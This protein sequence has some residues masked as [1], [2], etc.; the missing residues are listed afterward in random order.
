M[1]LPAIHLQNLTLGYGR[2]KLIQHV[3]IEVPN[4]ALLAVVGANGAGKSTLLKALMGELKPLQG[5]INFNG[6]SQRDIAYLPQRASVEQNFPM[7]VRDCVAMGLWKQI[8]AFGFVS[9]AQQSL[10]DQALASVGLAGM[11]GASLSSLS[12]GQMQRALFARLILQ[13][14][15]V[16]LLDEPFNAVDEQT[17]QDLMTLVT[18]WHR[19]GRTVLAVLH[20]L[21]LVRHY[22]PE[23][24]CLTN[25]YGSIGKTTGILEQHVQRWAA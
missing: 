15:P 21:E 25:G 6:F 11:S 2:H 16:I 22:F 5:S 18:Q 3:D 12:G 10:V 23:T 19:Q 7:N 14:A 17:I 8:G 13:D 4:G 1:S 9:S 20:D 24:L